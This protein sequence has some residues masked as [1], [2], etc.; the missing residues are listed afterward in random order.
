M[1]LDIRENI[2]AATLSLTAIP[3]R[4]TKQATVRALNRALDQSATAASREIRHKYNIRHAAV[5]K[6]MKKKRAGRASKQERSAAAA[7]R[8]VPGRAPICQ[9]RRDPPAARQVVQR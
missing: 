3:E 1:R 7:C 5:L 4:A 9:W 6:A 2:Q 8:A